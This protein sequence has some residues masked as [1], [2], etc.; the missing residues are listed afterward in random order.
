MTAFKAAVL[1]NNP[2]PSEL[3]ALAT[4]VPVQL[5][6]K[7]KRVSE[8]GSIYLSNRKAAS[9][10]PAYPRLAGLQQ[11]IVEKRFSRLTIF[12][13][14]AG[15]GWAARAGAE[16]IEYQLLLPN[17]TMQLGSQTYTGDQ[18]QFTFI[19]DDANVISGSISDGP[20]SILTYS[21]IYQ[22]TA[23]VSIMDAGGNVLANATFDPNQIVVSI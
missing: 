6:L 21:A 9:A 20:S 7:K 4:K 10:K 3:S 2:I 1:Q 22:G 14:C 11:M 17:A 18:V 16:P 8:N 5:Q 23:S 19:G 15:L 12:V 13:L